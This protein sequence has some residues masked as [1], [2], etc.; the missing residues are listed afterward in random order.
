MM[1][2]RQAID[3]SE[4]LLQLKDVSSQTQFKHFDEDSEFRSAF[5]EF[6]AVCDRLESQIKKILSITNIEAEVHSDDNLH[7][8]RF[9]AT[10]YVAQASL[11]ELI[12]MAQAEWA[13]DLPLD[14]VA[15]FYE[16]K[17]PKISVL[18]DYCRKS[19]DTGNQIGFECSIS[20]EKKLM[21]WLQIKRPTVFT[22]LI[23][24]TTFTPEEFGIQGETQ[25]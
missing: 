22:G 13:Y 17:I 24:H 10:E 14:R 2:E 18:L 11:E 12:E 3:L 16:D 7:K 9:D 5:E 1:N 25:Q 19:R 8:V 6:E 20:D 23:P 4:F 15:L 21:Q